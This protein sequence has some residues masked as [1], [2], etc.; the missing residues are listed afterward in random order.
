M[1]VIKTNMYACMCIVIIIVLLS[2][3]YSLV[4]W[5]DI[6]LDIPSPYFIFSVFIMLAAH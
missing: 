3:F 1:Y 5:Y 6:V 4:H 2:N